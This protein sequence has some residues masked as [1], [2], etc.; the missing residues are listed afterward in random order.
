MVDFSV[1]IC[2]YNG[3]SRLPR[4]LERLRSQY[5]TDPI[6]WE[7]LIVDN[8]SSDATALVVQSYQQQPWDIQLRYLFEPQQGLAYA[9]RC[10]VRVAQGK[11]IGFLDD[12]TLPALNWLAS[13]YRFS[14][15]HPEAG[16]FGGRICGWFEAP[17]PLNFERI[18]SCLAVIDRGEFAFAY[19]AG[20]GVLPAGAGM[21]I[22]TAAWRQCVAAQPWLAGVRGTSLASKGEDVETLSYIRQAGY[23]IWYNPQM[24]LLHHIAPER[25][26][27]EYLMRMFR[28]IGLSRYPLRMLGRR[29]WQRPLLLLLHGLNDARRLGQ[30]L[31]RRRQSLHQQDLVSQCELMLYWSSLVSPLHYWRRYLRQRS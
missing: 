27:S 6:S 11:W 5:C 8:N 13:A 1:V 2:T 28:G 10:A 18:A 21:V 23:P 25:L 31:L 19:S 3:A 7:I 14:Q 9:R 17:P 30:H 29:S 12:D 20:R 22:N 4:V 16:A 15:Q 24:Q 26:Q